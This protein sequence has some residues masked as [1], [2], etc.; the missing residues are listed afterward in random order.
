M[1]Y[2]THTGQASN[3]LW[4]FDTSK[5]VWEAVDNTDIF[6]IPWSRSHH[7]M[8]SVGQDLWLYGDHTDLWRFNTVTRGWKEVDKT[9]GKGDFPG[10]RSE[11]VMTSVG[12]DLWLHG[13]EGDCFVCLM[14]TPSPPVWCLG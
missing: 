8:S 14:T 7:V 1:T 4:R 2:V 5:R 12:M 6:G 13:G 3:D 10:G 11:H 9:V